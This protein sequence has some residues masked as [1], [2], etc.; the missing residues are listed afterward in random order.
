MAL[1]VDT[2]TAMLEREIPW[3]DPSLEASLPALLESGVDVVVQ[4]AWIPR[5]DPDPRGT[6]LGKVRRIRNMVRQSQ[7][8][9]AVVTG[10]EQLEQ[11]VRE[12]RLAVVIALEGGTALT[13][14]EETLRELTDLGLS[15]VGLTWTESSAYADSSAEPRSGEAAGLTP[16][17]ERMVALCNDLGLMLDVSHMSDLATKQTVELSRAPVL[18]S[19]S[20]A[21]SLANVPRN[22]TDEQLRSIASRGGLVGVM[23]HGPFVRAGGK[24]SRSDVVKQVKF[25]VGLL[26]AEHVGLGSDW[27]GKIQSP[28]GLQGSRDLPRLREE[29]LAAGLSEEQVRQVY[30]DGFLRFWKDVRAARSSP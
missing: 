20:N 4:A 7:G 2:V 30:G 22:L 24:T 13:E 1:H 9:A 15:M 11:V 23:F 19:H 28:E 18:A 14:G 6:A 3:T 26:G 12:G 8:R 27:D 16:A 29:L 21:R 25:L 5:R 10:P 17:G